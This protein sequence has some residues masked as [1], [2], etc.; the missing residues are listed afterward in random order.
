MYLYVAFV[1]TLV[2]FHSYLIVMNLTTE[3]MMK[4]RKLDYMKSSQPFN[5]GV[6]QNVKLTLLHNRREP[7]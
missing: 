2:V 6:C 3:E 1:G 5:E 4:S 7:M